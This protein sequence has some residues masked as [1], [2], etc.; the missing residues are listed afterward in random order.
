[1]RGNVALIGN[2]NCG[3]T[4]IFNALTGLKQRVGN[5]PGVTVEKKQG[6]LR[7]NSKELTITDLPGTYSLNIVD[8][9]GSI[10]ERIVA[11]YLIKSPSSLLVNVIDSTNLE[12]NL[13]LSLQ[14]KETGLPMLVVLNMLDLSINAGMEI[15]EKILS[16]KL[17]C[18]VIKLTANNS[19][20]IEKLK[21]EIIKYDSRESKS[22]DNE[23]EYSDFIE[24]EVSI[25]VEEIHNCEQ[26]SN[27]ST[28]RKAV[29]LIEG[30][31]L[32]RCDLA[33][34]IY[35][36]VVHAQ[37]NIKNLHGLDA[38]IAIAK[39]R[40][41]C[42]TNVVKQCLSIKADADEL[43]K[44][45]KQVDK[46]VLSRVF[47]LPLFISLMYMIFVLAINLGGA[48]QDFFDISSHAVFIDQLKLSLEQLNSPKWLIAILA[49]GFGKGINTV[50]TF[51]PVLF[52]MFFFLSILEESGYMV[53][54]AFLMD[55][56]MRLIGLP[57]KSF[58]PMIVGFGCNVPSV[59][60]A[61]TL[62]YQQDRILT[63]MLSPFMSCS[64]RLAIFTVF[65]AAFFQ[66]G[67]QNIIFCLYLIG[68]LMAVLT[69][70]ILKK[71]LLPGKPSPMVLELSSYHLPSLY[72]LWKK[73][74][75]K[76]RAFLLKA[77]KLI[78]PL[79]MLIGALNNINYNDPSENVNTEQDSVL[80]TTGK[81]ITP[82]F[83]PMGISQDNWPATL[84][85]LSGVLA[86]EVV[87]GTLNALYEGEDSFASDDEFLLSEE[88]SRA[89][90][91]IGINISEL[92]NMFASPFGGQDI[93]LSKGLLGNIHKKFDGR[94]GAF[95]YLLFVLLYMPCVSVA[96]VMF[97][98]VGP[99]WT[100]F[101]LF[102]TSSLA[103]GV[104][105]SFYQMSS[106]ALH[107]LYSTVW[108]LSVLLGLALTI[109]VVKR[110]AGLRVKAFPTP[111][112][113]IK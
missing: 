105:T 11:D 24:N 17:N 52:V 8:E 104:S 21:Q 38:A 5:W 40:Y 51:I 59:L 68:I 20:D 16:E 69:G 54:A 1:M 13:Y 86:K 82:V 94:A 112:V 88:L 32:H 102:W 46:V 14:L 89:V 72:R 6:I 111:V 98:E 58:V 64:A 23:L 49:E 110:Y 97:R 4:T 10:D 44:F 42:I 7:V 18:P 85:L 12:R 22:N 41:S 60:A 83:A 87:V 2:P 75:N 36:A 31:I 65:V 107:P 50:V 25:L 15:D 103:Y 26:I 95:A 63:I 55:R 113:T 92:P 19:S 48:F 61:R 27:L 78:I 34:H 100:I 66:Q 106:F 53:R 81:F 74:S 71:T 77:G 28:R 39:D 56:L 101:S 99:G 37:N 33:P 35:S 73:T 67:G 109:W 62:E 9:H 57:G 3:K 90:N 93:S 70:L 29:A 43:N 76:L 47:G 91:S 30:D 80:A 84:G 108:V 96:G 45:T 79:C